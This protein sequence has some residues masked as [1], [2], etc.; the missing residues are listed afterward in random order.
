VG[1]KAISSPR[2]CRSFDE[3]AIAQAIGSAVLQ[4]CT[5]QRAVHRLVLDDEDVEPT[6]HGA[7]SEVT[8]AG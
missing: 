4:D 5:E 6:V 1:K 3:F 8:G 2:K 7:S